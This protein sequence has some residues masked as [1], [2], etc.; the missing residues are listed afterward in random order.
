MNISIAIIALGVLVLFSHVFNALFEKTKIPNVLLLMLIGLIIGPI[1]GLVKP[2]DLGVAGSIF[3][4][5][6][7]VCVLFASGTNLNFDALKKSIGSAIL[8]TIF[9]FI[10]MLGTCAVIGHFALQLDWPHSFYI[11]AVLGGTSS[12]VVIPMLCQL[13]PGEKAG[14]VLLLESTISDVI[15]LAVALAFYSGIQTGEMD[16]A[17]AAK[18]LGISITVA[19]AIGLLSGATWLIVLK[20]F[21]TQMENSHFTSFALAF[22]LYGLCDL[23]GVNGGIAVLSYGIALGNTDRIRRL[24]L[25][26]RLS[27]EMCGLNKNERDFFSEIVFVLQTYFF[28]Y[29]GISIQLGNIW[30]VLAGAV[31]VAICYG[32]RYIS[33][34]MVRGKEITPRDR[35]LIT[36]LGPKGL[37]AAVL[38]T[39]PLQI[40]TSE[41]MIRQGTA[42]RNTAY[43]VVFLSILISSL[44]VI[45]G[46]SRKAK[47]PEAEDAKT[48]QGD[49]CQADK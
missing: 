38:A 15:C 11:G 46:E 27:E 10:V 24:R 47:S 48:P 14:T 39:L 22:I 28:V 13:K 42:V 3:T 8:L 44:M 31:I 25:R 17:Q 23:I 37:I 35:R 1:T 49:D 5:V 20:K 16:L 40:A 18:E 45:I 9:N 29:I 30:G 43:A 21:L 2:E 41:E 36:T 6:T 33:S 19:L 34:F 4:T 7:L 12:A 26:F 32:G